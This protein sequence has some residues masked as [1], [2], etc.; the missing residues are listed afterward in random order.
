MGAADAEQLPAEERARRERARESASGIVSYAVDRVAA[1]AVFSL[2]GELFHVDLIDGVANRVA[3]KGPV[4]APR[5]S[6][7]GDLIAFVRD[8]A[9]WIVAPD[10]TQERRLAGEES[11][12]VSWGLPEFIAGE[13]MGRLRGFWWAPSGQ[14][15]AV[16]RVDETPV[17]QWHIG[18]PT[19]PSVAPT[20]H[21]YPAA[22]TANADVSLHLVDRNGSVTPVTWDR[23]ALPYLADVAWR[24]DEP[25][26]VTVQARDQQHLALL[27]VDGDG[28]TTVVTE[29]RHAPWVELRGGLPRRLP[30]GRLVSTVEHGDTRHLTV[31]G[32]PVTPAGV[33]VRRLIAASPQRLVFTASGDD[34]TAVAVWSCDLAGNGLQSLSGTD[35][36]ADAVVSE[37]V[38]VVVERTLVRAGATATVRRG[39]DDPIAIA[40]LSEHPDLSLNLTPLILG[41]RSLRGMLLLPRDHTPADGPL[42]VLLDP[43]G[44]PHAQRAL[45]SFDAH[46]QSQW[47]A[48]AGFA[49]LV[50]D[51]RGS[52]GRGPAWEQTIAGD[53]ASAPL[54]DQVDALAACAELHPGLLDLDRVAIKG[55][56]FGGYLAA[57]A[58]LRRPDI[59]A[60]AVAGAPVTDWSLYDTHYTERYLG[61]DPSSDTYRRSSLL[62]DA[63]SLRRPLLLIHGLS[64]D[65][66]VA[67]HTLRLS[68]ALLAAGRPH[69][70]LPLAGVTHMTPQ[71]V[72]AE[73]LFHLQL[74]FLRSALG[75][76]GG[77][78][79]HTAND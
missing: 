29:E 59:F 21:R 57:L 17:L 62:D 32:E 30:D 53:L 76:T 74:D 70:V 4:L 19:D 20:V 34:P 48:D 44:G 16:A 38:A 15:L 27:A 52:P 71:E 9:L 39:G 42:P 28:G 72:V 73:N 37:D 55:W 49:V 33:K 66:V 50:V 46:L 18:D 45:R 40:S 5:L 43:Y 51:G 11:P 65:N 60:A 26:V 64:D 13:E 77:T 68:R 78:V 56:S 58:V 24:D 22:G 14:Q 63:T 41:P 23:V 31:D 8:R 25:L 61:G 67:A 69:T 36:V 1:A 12:E 7:A 79:T 10:G 54:E 6:P 3:V 75:L 35:G 47:F 2:G